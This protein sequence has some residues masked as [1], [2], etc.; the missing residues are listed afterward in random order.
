MNLKG[1]PPPFLGPTA[2]A[3]Q[4]QESQES[5]A[6]Q[7]SLPSQRCPRCRADCPAESFVGKH[8]RAV[9]WCATCREHQAARMSKYRRTDP[10]RIRLYAREYYAKHREKY[11]GE[12]RIRWAENREEAIARSRELY[13]QNIEKRRE[14][15]RERRAKDPDKFRAAQRKRYLADPDKCREYQRTCLSARLYMIKYN[16][17]D[18]GYEFALSDSEAKSLVGG[19]CHYCGHMPEDRLNGI[20][21]VDNK[22]GYTLD[23]CVSACAECN[24]GKGCLDAVTFWQRCAHFSGV[25]EFPE[26][27]PDCRAG[28]YAIYKSVAVKRNLTFDLTKD[29]F[30]AVCA[31]ECTYCGKQPSDAHTNGIDRLDS[32]QGY[33]HGNVTACC[34]ECNRMKHTRTPTQFKEWALQVAIHFVPPQVVASDRCLRCIVRRRRV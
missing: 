17:R 12:A 2:V 4:T 15:D 13:A 28:T 6:P 26:A 19:A 5:Q 11:Q 14:R 1:A 9:R 3:M 31:R 33:T 24:N 21:R 8:G 27:F 22:K 32:S 25:R 29:E 34:G 18:R 23:N 20:D 10:E 30:T 16:A 7:E